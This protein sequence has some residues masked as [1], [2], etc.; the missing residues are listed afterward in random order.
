MTVQELIEILQ[1][2]PKDSDILV[3]DADGNETTN[4]SVWQFDKRVEIIGEPEV[5][6]YTLIYEDS[7]QEENA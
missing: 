3:L 7:I 5:S 6:E 2:L 4:I 1:R